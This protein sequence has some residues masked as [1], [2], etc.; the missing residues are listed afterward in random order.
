M[1]VCTCTY[2]VLGG[3]SAEVIRCCGISGY[4][5][6]RTQKCATR[7][8]FDL[9]HRPLSSNKAS[10]H[11]LLLETSQ[12]SPTRN[13]RLF[14][15]N[16]CKRIENMRRIFREKLA[17]YFHIFP[18]LVRQL[19]P[20]SPLTNVHRVITLSSYKV[21]TAWSTIARTWLAVDSNQRVQ[22]LLG[23][24]HSAAFKQ[25]TRI[26][27]LPTEWSDGVRVDTWRHHFLDDGTAMLDIR[28]VIIAGRWSDEICHVIVDSRQQREVRKYEE[29]NNFG[30]FEPSC[31]RTWRTTRLKG[32]SR[33]LYSS[34]S[35]HIE[36]DVHMVSR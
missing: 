28:D 22:L 16:Y 11:V 4:T 10:R 25:N 13:K 30:E 24:E 14:R 35:K 34:C 17:E 3:A 32:G 9:F 7:Y 31:L 18:P 21:I 19:A 33:F 12:K 15:F 2:C 8:R 6:L 26:K 23:A 1:D 27:F 29:S 20:F 5:R 36:T